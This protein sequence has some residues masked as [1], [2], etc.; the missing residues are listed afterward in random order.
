MASRKKKPKRDGESADA[1]LD[2]VR[3]TFLEVVELGSEYR[4]DVSRIGGYYEVFSK[5][6]PSKSSTPRLLDLSDDPFSCELNKIVFDE[7][8]VH[9]AITLYRPR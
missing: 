1:L 7:R 2:A 4:L 5:K 3:L 8:G 9:T 6:L